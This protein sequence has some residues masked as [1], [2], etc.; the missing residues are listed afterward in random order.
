MCDILALYGEQ[1][2]LVQ[3]FPHMSELIMLCKRRMTQ[4]LEGGLISCLALLKYII[5]YLSDSALMD[6]LQVS[7]KIQKMCGMFTVLWL[8]LLFC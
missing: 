5:P 7:L 6:Q 8:V 3:Y 2:I 4:N 1:L